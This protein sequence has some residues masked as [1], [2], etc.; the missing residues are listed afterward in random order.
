MLDIITVVF[1]TLDLV[2]Y[3]MCFA[4]KFALTNDFCLQLVNERGENLMGAQKL[5]SRYYSVLQDY[6]NFFSQNALLSVL[7]LSRL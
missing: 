4:I 1:L 5:S 2:K 7:Y 3:D 6:S